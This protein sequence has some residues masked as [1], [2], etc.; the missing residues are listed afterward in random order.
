[1]SIKRLLPLLGVLLLPSMAWALTVTNYS[2]TVNDRFSSGFPTDPVSNTAGTFIGS[3]YDWSGVAWS[4][5]TAAS[6]NFYKNHGML[7]PLHFLTAQHFENTNSSG[8][9]LTQGV[10]LLG[11][12]GTVY[13]ANTESI[14]NLGYGIVLTLR[15]GTD[16]DLAVG[17]L[18]TPVASAS[19]FTRYAVLDLHTSSVA[20]STA[21]Y[22]GLN[23][24]HYGRG[25]TTNSSPRIA[26]APIDAF[27]IFNDDPKQLAFRS[28]RNT[29]LLLEGGDS[30]S[31]ALHG[32]TNPNG[33]KELTFLGVN[34]ATNADFNFMSFL[35]SP[36]AMAS[37]NSV[38]TSDG[39]ALKVRGN[40]ARTWLGGNGSTDQKAHL[41]RSQNWSGGVQPSDVYVQFNASATTFL[42]INVNSATHLRGLYFLSTAAA[43]DGFNFGG[44]SILTIGRGGITN[45]DNARQ[46]FNAPITLG[47]HQY[48]DA[49]T[50]GVTVNALNTNGRLLEVAGGGTVMFN[51]VISGSGG[52]A[53]SGS[54]LELNANNTY[55]GKTWVHQ[56]ELVVNG[57][58]SSSS[59]FNLAQGG[60]LSGSGQ[61]SLIRGSGSIHPG[62]SPG[63][64]TA[65]AIDP[66]PGM[67]FFFEFTQLGSPDYGNAA[68][69]G[70]D[71]LRLIDS[72]PFLQ[73]LTGDN[74]FNL[75][76]DFGQ[77]LMLNDTFRGGIFTDEASSFDA[78][79]LDAA[80]FYFIADVNGSI[81]YHGSSYS[82]YTGP[83]SFEVTTVAALAD[84]GQGAIN[85]YVM[86]FTVIPEPGTYGLI[87]GGVVLLLLGYRRRLTKRNPG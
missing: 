18:Q 44:S 10:R 21:N 32:W 56:G 83:L 16:Y 77:S 75:Y 7:S 86:E 22:V 23:V 58:S 69:S 57:N 42:N 65:S 31:P 45:Y 70:N 27:N 80:F 51:G 41:S 63:I 68:A 47:D 52:L 28:A 1:M 8:S 9:D 79:I 13:T 24:L 20:N 82:V 36:D 50:G 55:T 64:L 3:D 66:A 61:V 71:V 17:R 62:Q 43:D 87:V 85:G 76:L 4:T 2:S 33:G 48:W 78:F 49:G 59:E 46:V 29:G 81:D 40:P 5:N 34:S 25:G 74:A 67:G 30:A 15:G 12:D 53:L 72:T 11:Q 60:S 39:F 35:A 26:S 84:F 38:M 19:N 14:N 6:P 73:V 54:R 37:A